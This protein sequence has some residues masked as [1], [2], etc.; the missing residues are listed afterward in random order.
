MSKYTPRG[1]SYNMVMAINNA[2][3]NLIG[4]KLGQHC[5]KYN[6]S[7]LTMAAKLGVSRAMVYK[8]VIGE[9]HPGPAFQQKIDNVFA[10]GE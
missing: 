1:F 5:V 8:W 2:D 7:I 10:A 9:S 6:V 3:Q 4:V